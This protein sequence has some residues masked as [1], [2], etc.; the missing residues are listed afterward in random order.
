MTGSLGLS[1][2]AV[3]PAGGG[4]G[5]RRRALPGGR[6]RDDR[7]SRARQ[8]GGFNAQKGCHRSV[9]RGRGRAQGEARAVAK[10]HMCSAPSL[11]GPSVATSLGPG[12]P[13]RLKDSVGKR[14]VNGR[15]VENPCKTAP[16]QPPGGKAAPGS[17]IGMSLRD[18]TTIAE[19]VATMR[20]HDRTVPVGDIPMV[21]P[22]AALPPGDRGGAIW[23]VPNR[24]TPDHNVF[25]RY[26]SSRR[27]GPGPSDHFGQSTTASRY[28][29]ER[30]CHRPGEACFR[31][32]LSP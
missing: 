17:S 28:R 6:R 27:G 20:N 21:E 26:P 7:R 32:I 18:G 24:H 16:P 2:Q 13:R 5:A 23:S 8:G 10:S 25:Q 31:R 11:I 12:P 9:A 29:H 30:L 3:R 19:V 14:Y 15:T 4:Q 22:G 1:S